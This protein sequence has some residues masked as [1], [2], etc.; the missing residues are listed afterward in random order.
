MEMKIK[1]RERENEMET[2]YGERMKRR[3]RR[4]SEMKSKEKE[5]E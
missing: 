1:E 2:E 3:V 5:G 4:G